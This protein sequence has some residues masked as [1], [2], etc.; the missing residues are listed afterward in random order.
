MEDYFALNQ[1]DRS[2]LRK[3]FNS[4]CM[5]TNNTRLITQSAFVLS[6]ET[7]GF[8]PLSMTKAGALISFC[9]SQALLQVHGGVLD[10]RW[11]P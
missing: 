11:P 4:L 9:L 7:A 8:L 6:L 2:Q 1:D 5:N 10:I 3:T